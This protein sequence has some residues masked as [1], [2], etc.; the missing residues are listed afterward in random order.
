VNG[1]PRASRLHHDLDRF[2]VIHRSVA[3]RNVTELDYSVE[4]SAGLD[5]SLEEHS[6]PAFALVVEALRYRR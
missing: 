1:S 3:A 4:D 2:P 5:S 6:S